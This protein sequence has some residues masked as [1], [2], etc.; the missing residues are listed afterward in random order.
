MNI[1][2]LMKVKGRVRS[3]MLPER[4][5]THGYMNEEATSKWEPAHIRAVSSWSL[6]HEV[7]NNEIHGVKDGDTNNEEHH[8][9]SIENT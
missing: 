2:K 3:A 4:A 5:I 1:I 8:R 6:N 7:H 9:R